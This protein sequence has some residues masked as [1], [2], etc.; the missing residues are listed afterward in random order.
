MFVRCCKTAIISKLYHK[1]N[2]VHVCVCMVWLI[3]TKPT[4]T[5]TT[6]IY[7]WIMNNDKYIWNNSFIIFNKDDFFTE[8]CSRI[9]IIISSLNCLTFG[10]WSS[11]TNYL[12][13]TDS[14]RLLKWFWRFFSPP[15]P[16]F[17]FC[18]VQVQLLD[19]LSTTD[20]LVLPL[21]FGG[22]DVLSTFFPPSLGT[23]FVWTVRPLWYSLS[24]AVLVWG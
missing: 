23:L 8:I 6:T 4:A 17:I 24:K 2:T 14:T 12:I 21:N 22:L 7:K 15:N 13:P 1:L 10:W 11:L 5:T 18:H 3:T 16:L 19:L 20:E 9:W